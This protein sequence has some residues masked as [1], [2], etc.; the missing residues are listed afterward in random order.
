MADDISRELCGAYKDIL[1][2]AV[3][4]AKTGA[5]LRTAKRE[6]YKMDPSQYDSSKRAQD[7]EAQRAY[8]ETIMN[9]DYDIVVEESKQAISGDNVE[10]KI[11]E[12]VMDSYLKGLI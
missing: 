5:E 7:I 1:K 6:A 10:K 9:K 11:N 8:V 3:A 4:K 12:S 2:T